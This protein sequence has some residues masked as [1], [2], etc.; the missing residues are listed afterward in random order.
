MTIK[1]KRSE[2]RCHID[3][4]WLQSAHSFSFGHYYDPDNTGYRR[5]LVMNEDRIQKANAFEKH[6]HRDTEIISYVIEGERHHQD[7]MGSDS[8]A[9]PGDVQVLSSGAGMLH[10]EGNEHETV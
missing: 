8:I 4:G 2:E 10:S 3:H 1:I 6:G 7:T 9:E 5:L